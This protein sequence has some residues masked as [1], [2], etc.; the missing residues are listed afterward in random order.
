MAASRSMASRAPGKTRWA[1]P[2][3][4]AGALASLGLRKAPRGPWGR[5]KE[6][7]PYGKDTARAARER[8]RWRLCLFLDPSARRE[9][10]GE[11]QVPEALGRGQRGP[12]RGLWRRPLLQDRA[13]ARADGRPRAPLHREGGPTVPP[14]EGGRRARGVCPRFPLFVTTRQ[15]H[16]PATAPALRGWGTSP[17]HASGKIQRQVSNAGLGKS[18]AHVF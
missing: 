4:A 18:K 12:S 17:V 16:F 9:G 13:P 11:G 3:G 10:A 8:G 7:S 5:D 2:P 14:R 15:H 6:T 1:P